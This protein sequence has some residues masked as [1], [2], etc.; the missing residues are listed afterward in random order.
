[1]KVNA[2]SLGRSIQWI[3]QSDWSRRNKGGGRNNA[4][5]REVQIFWMLKWIVR[6]CH[7]ELCTNKFYRVREMDR[8]L[9]R[10]PAR[11]L[12]KK[13]SLHSPV[14]SAIRR[15]SGCLEGTGPITKGGR[16]L[17]GVITMFISLITVMV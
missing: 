10:Q 6:E 7:E 13:Q 8:V 2:G 11:S 14:R 16:K 17:W 3:D 5:M 15:I 1:M 4:R 12:R 9:R